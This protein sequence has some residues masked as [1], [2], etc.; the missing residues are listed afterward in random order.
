MS[1]H[2]RG[3][4]AAARGLRAREFSSTE[5]VH[6]LLDRIDEVDPRV[7]AMREVLAEEALRAAADADRRLAEGAPTG[8]LDGVPFTVKDNIDVAGSAT[9]QGVRAFAGAIAP[10]DAPAVAHLRRAGGIPLART[11]MPDF[12]LRWHTDSQIAGPT[13]NPWDPALT[14]GGSSGGEAVALATGMTPLGVGNDLGGSLRWPAQCNGIASL[15][16]TLGRIPHALSLEP[17]A[18]P[19]SLQFIE[20]QGPLA[21]RVED[22]RLAFGLMCAPDTRDPWHVALPA[23]HVPTTPR[24]VRV[25]DDLPGLDPPVRAAVARAATALEEQGYEIADASGPSLQAAAALWPHIMSA[26]GRRLWPE[27]APLASAE[28]GRFMDAVLA[29]TDPQDLDTMGRVFTERQRL[30]RS[31]SE[32]QAHTPLVIAPIATRVPFRAGDDLDGV[33]AARR[34]IESL[35]P[36]LAVNVLGLPSVAVPVGVIDGLPQA[37]QVIGPRFGEALCL[38]AAEAIERAAARMTPV[39]PAPQS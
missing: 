2:A 39:T 13:L 36:T 7:R 9:T 31:W 12:A 25:A 27:V 16:P 14:P 8:P 26:D 23:D 17:T 6:A 19:L 32:H 28:A 5:L 1:L 35:C 15:R 10:V 37:V 34:I 38:D 24:R 29:L 30:G 22:L 18:K 3:A 4:A 21:R 20:V 33:P 11:N